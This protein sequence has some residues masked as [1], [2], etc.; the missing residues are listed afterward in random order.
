MNQLRR[1]PLFPLGSPLLPDAVMPLHIFEQRYRQLIADLSGL[2]GQEQAFG[3]IAIRSGREVGTDHENALYEIGTLAQIRGI[4]P[5]ADGRFDIMTIGG[6][7]FILRELHDDQ[8][9]FTA[10][11]EIIG[12]E[13]GADPFPIADKVRLRFDRYREIIQM[14]SSV[15][16]LSTDPSQLSWEVAGGM[17]LDLDERQS[18]LAENNV[19]ARLTLERQLLHRELGLLAEIPSLPAF[20][21]RQLPMSAN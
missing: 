13:L 16:Q 18:I 3:V 6:E 7:R 8:E 12:E 14:E 19:T 4:Q 2:P 15:D 11:V 21:P 5:Y 9:Y 1:I 10:D 17:L 20:D